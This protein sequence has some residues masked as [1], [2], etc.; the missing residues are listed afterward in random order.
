MAVS[1]RTFAL[2]DREIRVTYH[3]E[4]EVLQ[5]EEVF[6]KDTTAKEDPLLQLENTSIAAVKNTQKYLLQMNE[7]KYLSEVNNVCSHTEFSSA[8]PSSVREIKSEGVPH[9]IEVDYLSPYLGTEKCVSYQEATRVKSEALKYCKERLMDR[10]NIIQTKLDH[11]RQRLV[12]T[13]ED[14]EADVKFNIELL[15]TRLR[16]HEERSVSKYRETEKKL[17]ED[18]RLASL[19]DVE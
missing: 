10:A 13:A 2:K 7:S 11:E 3:S 9:N 14:A 4:H 18:L 5:T 1:R 15:Q 17:A 8:Q 12:E 16:E 6:C 19:H